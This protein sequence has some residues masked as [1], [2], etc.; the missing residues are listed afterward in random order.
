MYIRWLFFSNTSP[1]FPSNIPFWLLMQF[2]RY[3]VPNNKVPNH[4]IPNNKVP[5]KKVLK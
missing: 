4:K 2:T 1:A 5:N 3:K